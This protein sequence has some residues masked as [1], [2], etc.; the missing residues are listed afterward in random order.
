[1]TSVLI[2]DDHPLFRAALRGAALEAAPH[3]VDLGPLLRSPG[4]RGR[5]HARQGECPLPGTG[6]LVMR[7]WVRRCSP[8]PSSG[9]I[10]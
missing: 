8:K 10:R 5:E 4:L 7:N 2:I 3:G 6:A 9:S 1:M